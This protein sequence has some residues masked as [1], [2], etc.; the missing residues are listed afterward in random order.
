MP[1]IAVIGA[2]A[3]R[4]KY[5]NRCVRAYARLGYMVYPIHPRETEI[6]GFPV[7]TSLRDVPVESVDLVS[8]YLPTEICLS[9]LPDLQSKTIGEVWFN[10]GAD[11]SAVL[12]KARELGLNIRQGCSIIAVGPMPE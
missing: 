7:F 4:R 6:E 5:G 10:P 3:D 1:T 12:Q 2:S 8:V 9:I 11:A